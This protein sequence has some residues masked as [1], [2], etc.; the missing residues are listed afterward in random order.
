MIGR[1]YTNQLVRLSKLV[2]IVVVLALAIESVVA[3]SEVTTGGEDPNQ[4]AIIQNYLA[5]VHATN[6]LRS[7]LHSHLSL[8]ERLNKKTNNVNE[9]IMFQTIVESLKKSYEELDSLLDEFVPNDADVKEIVSG[10]N[11]A[12]LNMASDYDQVAAA[13]A[14]DESGTASSNGMVKRKYRRNGRQP[15]AAAP[16][17]HYDWFK[18]NA[19]S[20]IPV[21]RYGRK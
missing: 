4:H 10:F 16:S 11:L 18:R 20:K 17:Q 21:I 5:K 9:D 13:Q 2:S 6:S 12:N 3:D 19:Y 7:Q 1:A 15:A 14:M 8:L